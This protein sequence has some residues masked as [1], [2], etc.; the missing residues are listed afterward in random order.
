MW[1]VAIFGAKSIAM[2]V[3][4]AVQQ[5]YKNDFEIIGFLVSSKEDNPDTLLG[6]PVYELESF[7]QKD[8]FSLQ[9]HRI[10]RK[11]WLNCWRN[12]GSIIIFVWIPEKNLI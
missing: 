3:C 12:M 7:T 8:V 6:L 10:Y 4:H 2:G 9:S 1:K 11:K 5:L